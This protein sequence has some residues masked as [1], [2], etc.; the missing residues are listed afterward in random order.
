MEDKVFL[1]E[2]GLG[3]VG[4][5]ISKFYASKDDIKDLDSLK[6]FVDSHN[7]I[8]LHYITQEE[9]QKMQ[10]EG[11]QLRLADIH[12][13]IFIVGIEQSANVEY[14]WEDIPLMPLYEMGLNVESLLGG[15]HQHYLLFNITPNQK[16]TSDGINN[17][18]FQ[19]YPLKDSDVRLQL[20]FGE[21][22]Q[23]LYWRLLN[24]NDDQSSW[25]YIQD[26]YSRQHVDHNSKK[27]NDLFEQ[28]QYKVGKVDGKDLSSNDY[29]D[30]DKS[31][32]DSINV[33]DITSSVK[34]S[35]IVNDLT[36]GGTDK[37]LSAEQGKVL[38]QYANEGKEKIANALIGKGVENV[39]K[40]SSFS[41]LAKGI[42]G[43]KTGYSVGDVIKSEDLEVYGSENTVEK[44]TS[45]YYD[46]QPDDAP[47]IIPT[48]NSPDQNFS[49]YIEQYDDHAE[50]VQ[51]NVQ[52][53]KE[54]KIIDLPMKR[55][56]RSYGDS[57]FVDND[58]II[59]CYNYYLF[60]YHRKTKAIEKQI[61]ILQICNVTFINDFSMKF[62]LTDSICVTCNDDC[63][64]IRDYLTSDNKAIN[65]TKLLKEHSIELDL[66]GEVWMKDNIL[67]MIYRPLNAKKNINYVRIDITKEQIILNKTIV[68]N[69]E[70]KYTW[71]QNVIY[72]SYAPNILY[73]LTE[74]GNITQ[75]K[76]LDG[77]ISY[78]TVLQNQFVV[79]YTTSN[80]DKYR[81]THI[82]NL[83]N[84]QLNTC[85]NSH[86][87]GQQARMLS[88]GMLAAFAQ[89]MKRYDIAVYKLTPTGKSYRVLK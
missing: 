85:L 66:L 74:N 19:G 71:S 23:C 42:N 70:K 64:V 29:T 39:S 82:F 57:I 87:L 53:A 5:V 17:V 15:N 68:E 7:E 76:T 40:D 58:Y 43:V 32:L 62:C 60:A 50:L 2:A 51:I 4:K 52:T 47:T 73:R 14:E 3:E 41:D 1:D 6:D 86:I 77:E 34:S 8:K 31:K 54:E 55:T 79:F 28:M 84:N 63:Y 69:D 9:Y 67:N 38:F 18:D 33:D 16:L 20:A 80:K 83:N 59:V 37:V 27:I 44:I 11:K 13:P 25:T 88:N 24:S 10:R 75:L 89:N 45:Y 12:D 61:N 56:A 81:N 26:P 36:T 65:I 48:I 22:D 46:L 49:Y 78:L 35:Q 30:A 72:D 21:K